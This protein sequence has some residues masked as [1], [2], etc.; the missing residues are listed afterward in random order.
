MK[1]FKGRWDKASDLMDEAQFQKAD[2]FLQDC[3]KLLPT[4][5]DVKKMLE[6]C[7]ERARKYKAA[8]EDASAFA[9]TK[10]LNKAD[11]QIKDALAQAPK[12]SEALSLAADLSKKLEK[13]KN[14][15]VLA[16][17]QLSWAEFSKVSETI[18]ELEQL[19]VDNPQAENTRKELRKTQDGYI[20]SM[21]EVRLAKD[22]KDLN[23]AINKIKQALKSCPDSQE[24]QS[25]S[26]AVKAEQDRASNLV[27]EAVSAMWSAEFDKAGSFLIQASAIWPDA[28]DLDKT[29]NSIETGQKKYTQHLKAAIE[30]EAS[31]ALGK[32]LDE[33]TS[34]QN[35]CPDSKEASEVRTSIEKKQAEAKARLEDAKV[36]LE[37]AR[38]EDV[39]PLA[40]KA[41]ELWPELN[42]EPYSASAVQTIM[43]DYNSKMEEA[44]QAFEAKNLK[45]SLDIVKKAITLCP[46]AAEANK[47]HG[48]IRE[49]I[50]KRENR[51]LK[52]RVFLS[53]L[54]DGIK[55]WSWFA[56]KLTVVI[57]LTALTAALTPVAFIAELICF[58]GK[59][60][61][62]WAFVLW[63]F[64]KEKVWDEWF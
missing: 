63:G 36:A 28:P 43:Q 26:K 37:E 49:I 31:L 9:K 7:R 39:E 59:A 2:K 30:A 60:E 10:M 47:L 45:K 29:K 18:N 8:F 40:V 23:K 22:S 1:G 46:R 38:F 5:K 41:K 58:K 57:L 27:D 25:F 12:S 62:N 35:E 42:I 44:K 48:S 50:K 21:E 56:A 3:L 20:A 6:T 11:T 52:I 53:D 55:R 14:L 32:A 4:R 34:A 13:T 16:Q 51:I 61:H 15:I 24:A 19:Q 33:I 17:R 54:K 64:L